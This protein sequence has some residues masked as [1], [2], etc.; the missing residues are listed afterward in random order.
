MTQLQKDL[1]VEQSQGDLLRDQDTE[2]KQKISEL[3]RTNEDL[4]KQML[5]GLETIQELRSQ[6]SSIE[7]KL[8]AT[9]KENFVKLSVA[10]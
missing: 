10:L 9:A 7:I 1:I 4:Q 5:V 8:Q 2:Q 3:E 6:V